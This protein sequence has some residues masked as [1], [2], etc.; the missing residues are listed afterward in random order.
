M[1]VC[2]IDYSKGWADPQIS[3][4]LWEGRFNV[5]DFVVEQEST[6]N[7]FRVAFLN[8]ELE[9][10]FHSEEARLFKIEFLIDESQ[11]KPKASLV[12]GLRHSITIDGKNEDVDSEETYHIEMDATEW[13]ALL[14]KVL[15]WKQKVLLAQE[16]ELDYLAE[17]MKEARL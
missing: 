11:D 10:L 1:K 13:M 14:W 5:F 6:D 2:E 7:N 8:E 9:E 3:T 17:Q 16:E 12:V 4:P 15:S